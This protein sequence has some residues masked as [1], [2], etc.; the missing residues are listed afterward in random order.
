M[1]QADLQAVARCGKQAAMLGGAAAENADHGFGTGFIVVVKGIDGVW[2]AGFTDE[3]CAL[4]GRA[5][6]VTGNGS[7]AG[8]VI[9]LGG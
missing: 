1:N 9:E 2:H 8:A 4:E 3:P 7:E 5:L 6:F